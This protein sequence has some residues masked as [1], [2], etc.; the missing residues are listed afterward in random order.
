MQVGFDLSEFIAASS[1]EAG[2]E[3]KELLLSHF[4]LSGNMMERKLNE[5]AE[6]QFQ[7]HDAFLR[8]KKM[9]GIIDEDDDNAEAPFDLKEFKD[10]VNNLF[11]YGQ[12]KEQEIKDMYSCLLQGA[13]IEEQAKP[14]P[15][16]DL[17]TF[18]KFYTKALFGALGSPS[19]E[20]PAPG[21][22]PE[23]QDGNDLLRWSSVNPI[24][25]PARSV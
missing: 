3:W 14:N 18:E 6:I 5:H 25:D 8:F 10:L 16:I 11:G 20:D 23:H 4:S 19:A 9:D 21:S 17:E 15:V 13:S 24:V 1:W 12:L 2:S 22:L 7:L